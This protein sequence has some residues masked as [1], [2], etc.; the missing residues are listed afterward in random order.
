MS[1][2]FLHPFAIFS[3]LMGI[4]FLWIWSKEKKM[5]G[6]I[7]KARALFAQEVTEPMTV[8]YKGAVVTLHP[9]GTFLVEGENDAHCLQIR[10]EIEESFMRRYVDTQD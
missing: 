7:Q 5:E 3:I 8:A 2:I 6:K 4:L 10:K 9:D 1:R